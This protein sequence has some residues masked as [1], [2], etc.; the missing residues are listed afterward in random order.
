MRYLQIRRSLYSL[1]GQ[2]VF[3]SSEQLKRYF[4]DFLAKNFDHRTNET[5]RT[6]LDT[7]IIR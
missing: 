6:A 4:E 2:W 1:T 3:I 7:K 5:N